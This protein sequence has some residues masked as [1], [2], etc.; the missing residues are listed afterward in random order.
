MGTRFTALDADVL[1]RGGNVGAQFTAL[2]GT[3]VEV[4]GGTIAAGFSI[5]GGAQASIYGGSFQQTGFAF[6]SGSTVD[7]YGSNFKLN[8][9]TIAGLDAI[10]NMVT[11]TER[12]SQFVLTGT[13]ADGTA[14]NIRLLLATDRGGIAALSGISSDAT[15]RL[16]RL[17]QAPLPGDFDGNGI[18]DGTDLLTWQRT[19]GSAVGL[20]KWRGSMG[21]T[22]AAAA[23]G[24]VP[25]PGGV[26]LAIAA[27]GCA[28]VVRRQRKAASSVRGGKR[29]KPQAEVGPFR[30]NGSTCDL[31][32][33]RRGVRS[34]SR[35]RSSDRCRRWRRRG[36]RRRWRRRTELDSR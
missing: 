11:V 35:G 20:A 25:E 31:T 30:Q 12:G 4:L 5:Y 18:V 21:L 3:E 32:R 1:I 26:S 27:L 29:A 13:L 14:L 7:L 9:Q 34:M 6:L 36:G 28:F 33:G 23:S 10:G 24:S 2:K 17:D 8:G 16:R 22:N 15:L 19:G